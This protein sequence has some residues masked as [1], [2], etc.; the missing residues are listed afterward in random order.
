VK[1][2]ERKP[3]RLKDYDYSQSGAY[4]VTICTKDH[5]HLF[6]KITV[7]A[8]VLARPNIELSSLGRLVNSAIEHYNTNAINFVFDR[9]AIMPNHLHAI[10]IIHDA[11]GERGRSPL[12]NIVRNLKGY[13]TKQAGKTSWQKS[14]HDHINRNEADYLRIAQYIENNPIT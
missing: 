9:C 2:P 7:G 3:N 4:F 10:I 1:L 12:R 13:V 14:F 5:K 11:A 8:S 6:G